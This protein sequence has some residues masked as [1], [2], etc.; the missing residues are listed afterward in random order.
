MT[1]I[2]FHEDFLE[3]YA[4]DPAASPGRLDPALNELRAKYPFQRPSQAS[5][6]TVLR[7]HT[8]RHL[9]RVASA[10]EKLYH[11]ALLSLGAVREASQSALERETAFALC[12]PPGHH[13]GKDYSWGFCYF[14]NIAA[15]VAELLVNEQAQHAVIVDFDLHY[16]DGT[17][18]IFQGQSNVDFWHSRQSHPPDFIHSLQSF[19]EGKSADVL[20]VSAGF[21]RHEDDWGSMLSTEDYRKI[22]SILGEFAENCCGGRVFAALEGGYNPST[23]AKS[24]QAF[25]IGMEEGKE[26]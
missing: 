18:D 16:G 8:P 1:L 23:L 12:R 9:R 19:L 3:S 10:G 2:Y 7:V 22:G 6:E 11:T 14:N 20:A 5:D 25:L 21:D 4:A 13:A 24:I 17:A 26:Q 15:S